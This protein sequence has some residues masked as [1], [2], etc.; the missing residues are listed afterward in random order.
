MDM[1][2]R[3]VMTIVQRKHFAHV[4]LNVRLTEKECCR[5]ANQL[6]YQGKVHVVND[7]HTPPGCMQGNPNF[8]GQEYIIFNKFSS[9]LINSCIKFF[10]LRLE[11]LINIWVVVLKAID[12]CFVCEITSATPRPSSGNKISL[13]HSTLE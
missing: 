7:E 12:H 13:S 4:G 3:D 5:A 8:H 1:C 2:L 6:G 9:F 11:L 10:F